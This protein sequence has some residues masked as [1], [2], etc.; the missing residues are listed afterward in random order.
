M[1]RYRGIIRFL[2]DTYTYWTYARGL[3]AAY[4]NCIH[5]LSKETGYKDKFLFECINMKMCDIH[6]VPVKKEVRIPGMKYLGEASY[7]IKEIKIVD[8]AIDSFSVIVD[9]TGI[10]FEVKPIAGVSDNEKDN[11]SDDRRARLQ[12]CFDEII[13]ISQESR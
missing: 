4:Y 3:N 1:K 10:I 11:R 8:F 12:S 5:K 7:E 2:G 6:E 13:R 9:K